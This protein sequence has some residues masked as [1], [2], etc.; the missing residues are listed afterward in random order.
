MKHLQVFPLVPRPPSANFDENYSK[1]ATLICLI[2]GKMRENLVSS[3][4]LYQSVILKFHPKT[5]YWIEERSS[6]NTSLHAEEPR[7]RKGERNF[8][9]PTCIL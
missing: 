7:E 8:R 1:E 5:R 3:E 2:V 9:F 6:F 4:V